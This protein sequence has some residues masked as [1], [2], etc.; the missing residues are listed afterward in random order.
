M[1]DYLYKNGFSNLTKV[2]GEQLEFDLADVDEGTCDN[3]GV[4]RTLSVLLVIM[5]TI[6]L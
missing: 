4:M 3:S 1:D 2:Q 5:M 6:S